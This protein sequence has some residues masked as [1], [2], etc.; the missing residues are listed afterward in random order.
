MSVLI[1]EYK[2]KFISFMG[3]EGNLDKYED[4]KF[5]ST[6]GLARIVRRF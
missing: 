6:N 5:R 2:F 3:T 1:T 4:D